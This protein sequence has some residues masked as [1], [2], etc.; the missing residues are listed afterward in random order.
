M[1]KFEQEIVIAFPDSKI[2]WTYLDLLSPVGSHGNVA[3][4]LNF[5]T[6]LNNGFKISKEEIFQ[7]GN[8]GIKVI[9]LQKKNSY[10]VCTIAIDQIGKMRD[11]ICKIF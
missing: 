11:A 9:T 4:W 7:S 2:N 1:L 5:L 3:S 6:F 8:W 10:A